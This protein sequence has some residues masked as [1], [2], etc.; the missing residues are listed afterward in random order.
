[1]PKYLR[2]IWWKQA[3]VHSL[4]QMHLQRRWI[5]RHY[6]VQWT[7]LLSAVA[8]VLLFLHEYPLAALGRSDK[9]G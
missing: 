5:A 1:M 8:E 3:R 7:L 9:R 4:L 6:R 2:S